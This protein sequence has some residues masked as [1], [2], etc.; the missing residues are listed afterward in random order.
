MKNLYKEQIHQELQYNFPYHYLDL[1]PEMVGISGWRIEYLNL[2]KAIKNLTRPFKNQLIL[3]AGCGDGRF[4]YELKNENVKIIGVDYSKQAISFAK[5]FNP[6]I[7]FFVQD[8]KNLKLPYKFDYIVLIET[9]EHFAPQ[10]IIKILK[11]LLNVLKKE[12]KLILTTPS[13]NLPLTKKHYQHFTEESLSDILGPYFKITKVVGY[14]KRGFKRK[15]FN[16]LVKMIVLSP[17]SFKLKIVRKYYKFLDKYY[18]KNFMMS[19]PKY[20]NGL[21]AIC[22]KK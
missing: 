13:T 20:C 1:E 10:E 5:A 14:S 22:R 16:N 2:L 11:N 18:A 8:L 19:K 15:I 3:D 17:L 12:G 7:K 21:I 9:L 4:C 6:N